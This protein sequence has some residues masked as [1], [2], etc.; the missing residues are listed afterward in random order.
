MGGQEQ[1]AQV[2]AVR[3][4][5]LLT[6]GAAFVVLAVWAC[7]SGGPSGGTPASDAD[8]AALSRGIDAMSAGTPLPVAMEAA[9]VSMASLRSRFWPAASPRSA[10]CFR[11]G[12]AAPVRCSACRMRSV[13]PSVM[14]TQAG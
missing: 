14:T 4:R 11:V 10:W 8:V 6:C 3:K 7:S 9:T 5:I 1:R 13:S 12:L 2:R